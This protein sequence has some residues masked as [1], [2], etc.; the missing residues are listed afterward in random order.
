VDRKAGAKLFRM[1]SPGLGDSFYIGAQMET[2]NTTLFAYWEEIAGQPGPEFWG[3]SSSLGD[4]QWHKMEIYVKHNTP[5]VA[6]GTV[7][8]WQD[9]AV[10]QQATNIVTIATGDHWYPIYLMSNWSNNPGW[11]HDANNHVY[12]DEFEI[13][14]DNGTGGVGSL[15]DASIGV[16]GSTAAN[17]PQNARI[18]P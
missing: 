10:K 18:L 3:D 5:G 7:R 15:S 14:S 8:V 6:N 2:P 11:E 16:G 12:W 1:Y 13:Y 9:G 4:G 17:T